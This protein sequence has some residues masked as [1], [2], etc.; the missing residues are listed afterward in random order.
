MRVF[1][2][3]LTLSGLLVYIVF[4][5]FSAI[6]FHKNKIR[7]SRS[8]VFLLNVPRLFLEC[9]TKVLLLVNLTNAQLLV[10]DGISNDR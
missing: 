5:C 8:R 4:I 9:V 3:K 7:L 6:F 1:L 10:L 2:I